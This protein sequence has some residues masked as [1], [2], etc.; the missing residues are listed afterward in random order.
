MRRNH[1]NALRNP[2]KKT[3]QAPSAKKLSHGH[4]IR[5]PLTTLHTDMVVRRLDWSS[6]YPAARTNAPPSWLMVGRRKVR[7]LGNPDG[8]PVQLKND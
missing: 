8:T 5:T 6:Q 2:M 4:G 3:N 7:A 1:T